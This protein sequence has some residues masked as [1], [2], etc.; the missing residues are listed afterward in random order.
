MRF[1]DIGIKPEPRVIGQIGPHYFF[2]YG[3][4]VI[5]D[6]DLQKLGTSGR[7]HINLWDEDT[8]CDDKIGEDDLDVPDGDWLNLPSLRVFNFEYKIKADLGRFGSEDNPLETVAEIYAGIH[9]LT[10][11]PNWKTLGSKRTKSID[12]RIRPTLNPFDNR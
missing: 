7:F 12:F 3:R 8:F 11:K 6:S 2:V 4:I 5:E 10:R 1:E 9:F